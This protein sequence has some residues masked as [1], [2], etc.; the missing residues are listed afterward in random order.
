MW[1]G[2]QHIL[3][4]FTW[5]NPFCESLYT[6]VLVPGHHNDEAQSQ[7]THR[8][9]ALPPN[10]LAVL[11][12][13]PIVFR[14]WRCVNIISLLNTHLSS[15]SLHSILAVFLTVTSEFLAHIPMSAWNIIAVCVI[16]IL[17]ILVIYLCWWRNLCV[18]P[19][20]ASNVSEIPLTVPPTDQSD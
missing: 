12:S 7:S 18:D 13:L 15:Y 1:A 10:L 17:S 3:Q 16:D 5:W 11:F 20:R 6:L 4:R 14:R 2:P 8:I 19:R 9:F